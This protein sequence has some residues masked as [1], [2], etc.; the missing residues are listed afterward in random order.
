M[1]VELKNGF[2]LDKKK[3]K[4]SYRDFKV[5]ARAN[6]TKKYLEQSEYLDLEDKF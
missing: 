5:I 6:F 3:E 4:L 2:S 1:I